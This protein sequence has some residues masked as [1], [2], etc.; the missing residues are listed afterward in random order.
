[1][2]EAVRD[3]AD[4][5]LCLITSQGGCVDAMLQGAP[6][7]PQAGVESVPASGRGLNRTASL[8]SLSSAAAGSA[9]LQQPAAPMP[10]APVTTGGQFHSPRSRRASRY[11]PAQVVPAPPEG[12]QHPDGSRP[13]PAVQQR[14]QS[15]QPTPSLARSILSWVAVIGSRRILPEQQQHRAAGFAAGQEELEAAQ[16]GSGT[17]AVPFQLQL[18]VP[19]RPESPTEAASRGMAAASG[20]EGGGVTGGATLTRRGSR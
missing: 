9:E 4:G 5:P 2:Q 7:Q 17:C 16:L 14:Q 8:T 18:G 12:S 13:L 3:P 19:E 6:A 10:R 11:G 20:R 15:A 1:M